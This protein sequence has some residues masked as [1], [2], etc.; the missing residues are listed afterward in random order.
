M[1]DATIIAYAF[2]MKGIADGNPLTQMKLQKVVYFAE[3]LNLALNNTELVREEFQAWKYG[4]VIPVIYHDYKLY[5]SSPIMDTQW[6]SFEYFGIDLNELDVN[7]KKIMD[8][9]WKILKD[10]PGTQLSNW[11]HLEGS[12]WSKFY[13]PGVPDII[14][15]KEEIKEYFMQFKGMSNA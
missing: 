1:Y 12:P 11:T 9:T 14:I 8:D 4:P 2:V 7:T 6:L 3:G 5:G 15:P 10:I 13:Q